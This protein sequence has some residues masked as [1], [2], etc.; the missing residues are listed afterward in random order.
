MSQQSWQQY[1]PF[2]TELFVI[3]W[4]I[5]SI[6]SAC[7]TEVVLLIMSSL[8]LRRTFA[9]N[10][11]NIYLFTQWIITGDLYTNSHYRRFE[12]STRRNLSA[13]ELHIY[14]ATEMYRSG[15]LVLL[16]ILAYYASCILPL[17]LVDLLSSVIPGWIS[18]ENSL[19]TIE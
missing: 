3:S 12:L 9:L 4:S 13:L 14:F 15:T 7:L 16:F 17:Y 19:F 2:F 10:D 11:W 1:S 6:L 8:S 5:E 18:I